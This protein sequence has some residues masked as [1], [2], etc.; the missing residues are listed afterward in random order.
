MKDR[1]LC[2]ARSPFPAGTFL[3]VLSVSPV[4]LRTRGRT[5][6]HGGTAQWLTRPSVSILLSPGHYPRPALR[7][8]LSSGL[9]S[10]LSPGV[11]ELDQP[12]ELR[13][14]KSVQTGTVDGGRV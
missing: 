7:P 11:S 2:V 4:T 1:K 3:P 6:P 5:A 10:G 9:S 12:L 8:G 14:V 13:F